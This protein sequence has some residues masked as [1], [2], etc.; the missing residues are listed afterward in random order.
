VQSERGV[1]QPF[2]LSARSD[3]TMHSN[4]DG[5]HNESYLPEATA[6]LDARLTTINNIH[7]P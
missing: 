7:N 4:G 1:R 6:R 2:V 5:E 3:S